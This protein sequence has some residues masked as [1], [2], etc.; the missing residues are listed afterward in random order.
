MRKVTLKEIVLGALLLVLIDAF[1]LFVIGSSFSS[2]IRKIQGSDISLRIAPA[3][4]VYIFGAYLLTLPKSY[5]EAFLV[6]LAAYGIYDATNYSTLKN[7]DMFLGA[8]D[9]VWGGVLM[10]TAWYIKQHVFVF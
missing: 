1:W 8:A 7:Y 5:G 10:S 6:G 2:M 9:T 4:V 3:V